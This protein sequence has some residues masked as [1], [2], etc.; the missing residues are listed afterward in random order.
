MLK[1]YDFIDYTEKT[2]QDLQMRHFD[3]ELY[4]AKGIVEKITHNV[5]KNPIICPCGS[6]DFSLLFVK[7]SVGYYACSNCKTILAGADATQVKEYKYDNNLIGFRTSVDY[8]TDAAARRDQS[9]EELINWIYFRTFR[10]LRLRAFKILDIGNR[11]VELAK[12][13]EA[14]E[15]CNE[16]SLEDSI[17][18]YKPSTPLSGQADVVLYV[19][20]LQQ[21]L[22]PLED[23]EHAGAKL[24]PGGLMF[25]STRIGT[26]FDILTLR[27]HAKVFPFEHVFLPS[28]VLLKELFSKAGFSVLETTTPGTLDAIN[29]KENEKQINPDESFIKYMMQSCD[30][31][32]LQDFQRFLQKSG[33]SSYTQIVVRKDVCNNE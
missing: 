15:F 21:S 8:Q 30:I 12:K 6:K 31:N 13:I 16:Y 4:I 26:G 32:I 2:A 5:S 19:N 27:E 1:A 18:N 17:I 3:E 29:V 7:W 25:L 23:I 33:L 9:W 24:K 22:N 20:N 28:M 14:S 10:H 11:Y